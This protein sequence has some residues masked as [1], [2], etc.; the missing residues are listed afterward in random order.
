MGYLDIFQC[1]CNICDQVLG[2]F[3]AAAQADQ[4]GAD[5]GGIQLLVGHL[6][7]GV[8]SKP[9]IRMSCNIETLKAFGK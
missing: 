6:A 1:L 9:Y 5:A 3:Q 4:V 2:I 8:V 7:V